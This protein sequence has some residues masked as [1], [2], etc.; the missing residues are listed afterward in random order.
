MITAREIWSLVESR[1]AWMVIVRFELYPLFQFKT[2]AVPTVG[3]KHRRS[4][5]VRSA[6]LENSM[7]L[8]SSFLLSSKLQ[9]PESATFSHVL[10]LRQSCRY[11]LIVDNA[12]NR[13]VCSHVQSHPIDHSDRRFHL[14]STQPI[15][16]GTIEKPATQTTQISNT[17]PGRFRFME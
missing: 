2:L 9:P 4:V 14:I 12:E 11:D 3:R 17:L 1:C 16:H 6:R 15:G 5:S 13:K 7:L 8:L 10:G